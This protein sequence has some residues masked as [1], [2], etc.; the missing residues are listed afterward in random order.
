MAP[1]CRC[2]SLGFGFAINLGTWWTVGNRALE[3]R[4]KTQAWTLA[5]CAGLLLLIL[6]LCPASLLA[7]QAVNS[8]THRGACSRK[9]S[10]I[11]RHAAS[12]EPTEPLLGSSLLRSVVVYACVLTSDMT[13][14]P[15]AGGD[16]RNSAP[17]SD[18]AALL[19]R[20]PAVS[21]RPFT[22]NN[23]STYHRTPV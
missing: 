6:A 12:P 7:S 23:F 16:I 5:A 19:A 18:R 14:S 22:R 21:N 17:P 20:A 10:Y 11:P 8:C 1:P 15:G 2:Q 4:D 3:A 13:S 9:P